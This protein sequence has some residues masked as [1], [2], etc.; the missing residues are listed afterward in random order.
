MLSL[1]FASAVAGR[2]PEGKSDSFQR[3]ALR[4]GVRYDLWRGRVKLGMYSR[5]Y[6]IGA[7]RH[8]ARMR[9]GEVPILPHR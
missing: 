4:P 7:R 1:G 8:A 2:R 3:D 5:P 6:G 9:A